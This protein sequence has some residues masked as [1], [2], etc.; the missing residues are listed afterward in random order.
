MQRNF[1]K[2]LLIS[3]LFLDPWDP[4]RNL[5]EHLMAGNRELTD[6]CLTLRSLFRDMAAHPM[7]PGQEQVDRILSALH[8]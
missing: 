6:E 2:D 8:F 3:A 5:A 7:E 4:R 1:T